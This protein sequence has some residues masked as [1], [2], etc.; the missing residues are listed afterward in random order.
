MPKLI[1]LV[2]L[3]LIALSSYFPILLSEKAFAES[4]QK[5]EAVQQDKN[6][7]RNNEEE[8]TFQ[9]NLQAL[10]R[11]VAGSL[12][13]KIEEEEKK[14][15]QLNRKFSNGREIFQI[16]F[17]Y[18]KSNREL[19]TL[20]KSSLKE[21]MFTALLSNSL[22][23]TDSRDSQGNYGKIDS[24][25]ITYKN[26]ENKDKPISD[27]FYLESPFTTAMETEL[28]QRY[29]MVLSWVGLNKSPSISYLCQFDALYALAGKEKTESLS[30]YKPSKEFQ[31]KT[32]TE[33]KKRLKDIFRDR[34]NL[35]LIITLF[36]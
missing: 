32:R 4:T 28:A 17:F 12:V 33:A 20:I 35:E 11:N 19:K 9:R 22:E 30:I 23:I 2:T 6:D 15:Y 34:Q 36:Q 16:S 24:I 26:K 3:P 27:S 25:K 29:A 31:E 10:N 1:K 8:I 21:S 18:N 13:K 7:N 14:D 5:T